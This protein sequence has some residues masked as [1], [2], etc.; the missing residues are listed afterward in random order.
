MKQYK[1]LLVLVVALALA[2]PVGMSAHQGS[3]DPEDTPEASESETPDA[4]ES[5]DVSGTPK[6]SSSPDDD[7]DDVRSSSTPKASSTARPS[8][9]PER[10]DD[11]NSGPGDAEDREDDKAEETPEVSVPPE[12]EDDADEL[13]AE[14]DDVTKIEVNEDEERVEVK[15]RLRAKLFGVIEVPYELE[16]RVETKEGETKVETHGPWW[17][18]FASD[19]SGEVQD[20]MEADDTL[21]T[22]KNQGTI[23]STLIG[24]LKSLAQ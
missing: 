14:D 21:L 19:D 15:Y 4:S 1:Y 3:D 9:S 10:E 6:P 5:P 11:D 17:L 12:L 16:A 13:I 2:I 23:L 18:L 20:A 7:E 8:K 24:I 22:A